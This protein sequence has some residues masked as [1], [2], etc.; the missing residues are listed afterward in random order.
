VISVIW[1]RLDVEIGTNRTSLWHGSS[2]WLEKVFLRT[3][4]ADLEDKQFGVK[5][6]LPE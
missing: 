5:S 6:V 1:S 3:E 4:A 2:D